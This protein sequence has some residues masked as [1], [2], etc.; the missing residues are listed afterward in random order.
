MDIKATLQARA[1]SGGGGR[2]A[3]PRGLWR[4]VA[5]SEWK[6]CNRRDPNTPS[7]APA[8]LR[9]SGWQDPR[10]QGRSARPGRS[11]PRAV[12]SRSPAASFCALH[13]RRHRSLRPSH[14]APATRA[15]APPPAALAQQSPASP[16]C[17]PPSCRRPLRNR[18]RSASGSQRGPRGKG[19]PGAPGREGGRRSR[20]AA[21]GRWL[22]SARH[23]RRFPVQPQQPHRGVPPGTACFHGATECCF[24]GSGK[25]LQSR[26]D[27]LEHGG[28]IQGCPE[29][30]C[31][32]LLGALATVRWG[33]G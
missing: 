22:S 9:P 16:A 17:P 15:R 25:E 6:L 5:D 14:L 30:C 31:A 10:A 33:Q 28:G 18:F 32:V 11:E 24:L 2:S 20:A 29:N 26:E 13:G 1:Q 12:T 3:P 4:T 21:R 19:R 8:A 27:L 7:R 23:P